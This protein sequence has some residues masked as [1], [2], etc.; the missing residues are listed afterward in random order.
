MPKVE[1]KTSCAVHCTIRIDHFP[2]LK[3]SCAANSSFRAPRTVQTMFSDSLAVAC[4]AVCGALARHNIALIA[5]QHALAPWH[6]AGINTG[7]SALLGAVAAAPLPP[8][9]K[10][11][12]SVGACGAFTTCSTFS[13]D[14]V[15]MIEAEQFAKAA[16]YMAVNNVGS[17]GAAL[18]SY[19]LAKGIFPK[20]KP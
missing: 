15:M 12:V 17:V 9:M 8:A 14:V 20:I 19:K 7:G 3:E 18:G 2:V 4:G 10:L 5:T 1:A 11:C 16:S 13:M 6:I